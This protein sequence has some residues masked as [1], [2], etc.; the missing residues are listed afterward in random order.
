[1]GKVCGDARGQVL[2]VAGGVI[3]DGV[4]ETGGHA[5]HRRGLE[6]REGLSVSL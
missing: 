4:V 2:N 6:Q 3:R 5:R 1:M